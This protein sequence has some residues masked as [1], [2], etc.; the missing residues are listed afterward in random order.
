[1]MAMALILLAA[2]DPKVILTAVR[3]EADGDRPVVRAV[4]TGPVPARVEKDGRDLVLLL[5]GARAAEGLVLPT[6]VAEIDSVSLEDSAQ[7]VRI[8]IRLERPL[9]FVLRQ[10]LASA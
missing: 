10:L 8:R 9:P 2:S 4:V 5:P 7:G 1:M 6:A 3:L